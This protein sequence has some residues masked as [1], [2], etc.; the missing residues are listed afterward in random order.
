MFCPTTLLTIFRITICICF[1]S[2]QY[3]KYSHS[4]FNMFLCSNHILSDKLFINYV[5]G[6]RKKMII[7]CCI[8]IWNSREDCQWLWKQKQVNFKDN[9]SLRWWIT[10]TKRLNKIIR[11]LFVK[12]QMKTDVDDYQVELQHFEYRKY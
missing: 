9:I 1:V 10:R 6:Q 11:W 12:F 4:K 8:H 5:G 2:A 7:Q 3:T